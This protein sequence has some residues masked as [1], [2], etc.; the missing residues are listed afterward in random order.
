MSPIQ[1]RHVQQDDRIGIGSKTVTGA[2]LDH[3][4]IAVQD[5]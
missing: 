4:A 2:S 1:E 3:L 5:G